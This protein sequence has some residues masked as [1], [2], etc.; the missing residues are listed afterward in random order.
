M[1][2]ENIIYNWVAEVYGQSEADNPSWNIKMLAKEI[3]QK[4]NKGE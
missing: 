2:I 1:K 3:E 4:L